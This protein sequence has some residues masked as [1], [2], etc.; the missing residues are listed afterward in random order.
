MNISDGMWVA[1]FLLAS[2]VIS[3]FISRSEK[4]LREKKIEF[5]HSIPGNTEGK[6]N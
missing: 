3:I 4:K 1:L 5:F 2:G 6:N